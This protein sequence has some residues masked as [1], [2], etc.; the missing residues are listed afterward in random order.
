M[1]DRLRR[2]A[3]YLCPA[4]AELLTEGAAEIE[5]LALLTG[6]PDL[7]HCDEVLRLRCLVDQMNE[8][9]VDAARQVF[10]ARAAAAQADG[11]AAVIRGQ[12]GQYAGRPAELDRLAV[13][14]T[15][16]TGEVD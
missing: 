13:V 15:D 1:A 12:L 10:A 2:A 14:V 8:A 16:D 7:D 4:D 11:R 9:L 3:G 6:Q 5:R